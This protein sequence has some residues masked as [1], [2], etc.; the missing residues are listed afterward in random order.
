MNNKFKLATAVVALLMVAAIVVTFEACKKDTSKAT[1]QETNRELMNRSSS[2]QSVEN[3]ILH[4]DSYDSLCSVRNTL[5][6]LNT[7]DRLVWERNHYFKSFASKCEELYQRIDTT[8][9]DSIYDFAN[10]YND[11]FYVSN[12]DNEPFLT[13]YLEDSPMAYFVNSNRIVSVGCE[14][15]KF[16]D[17]G[18]IVAPEEYL[19]LLYDAESV[20]DNQHSCLEYVQYERRTLSTRVFESQ[21]GKDKLR[22][23]FKIDNGIITNYEVLLDI[24]PLHKTCGIWL[25]AKRT[26]SCNLYARWMYRINNMVSYNNNNAVESGCL[27]FRVL[28]VMGL[29]DVNASSADFVRIT[30]WADTPSVPTCV[31][32]Y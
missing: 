31:I 14:Y 3:N 29:I 5:L 7:E 1:P 20:N 24:R 27:S 30:G 15:Y 10:T 28:R 26:I 9:A 6:S 21:S 19:Y 12:I 25:F 16:F 22:V 8:S 18:Y 17:D 11:Y 32:N 23:T 4:F 2:F 13:T